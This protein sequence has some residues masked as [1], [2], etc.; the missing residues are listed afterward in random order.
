MH[1]KRL[2]K[3]GKVS[4]VQVLH[5]GAKQKFTSDLIERGSAEGWLS[6]G[7]GKVTVHAEGGD[8]RYRII[9][10]PGYYC[11]HCGQQLEGD[12]RIGDGPEAAKKRLAHVQE[13]HRGQPSP[14]P[15]NPSGYM[16]TTTLKG[17]KE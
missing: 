17:V 11:C 3:D 8:V 2:Y 7:Q 13:K 6:M 9:R 10:S 14:D 4:G 16:G 1:L 12:P 15:E 5:A